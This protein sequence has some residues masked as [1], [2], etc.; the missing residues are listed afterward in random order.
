ML[1]KALAVFAM[2]NINLTKVRLCVCLWPLR[3]IF[4]AF[5]CMPHC[6]FF[7]LMARLKAVHCRSRLY[8]H[9]TTVPLA[10]LSKCSKFLYFKSCFTMENSGFVS[11]TVLRSFRICLQQY[12]MC[13]LANIFSFLG[14]FCEIVDSSKVVPLLFIL[15][16]ISSKYH[17]DNFVI[18]ENLTSE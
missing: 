17:M 12:K 5:L 13:H 18:I 9:L 1:F 8:Q 16:S 11:I 6:N 10:F 4:D 14:Y 2:R 7:F 3:V 15:Y